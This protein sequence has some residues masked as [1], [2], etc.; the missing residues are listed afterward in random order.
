[1]RNLVVKRI[2]KRTSK[3]TKE[4]VRKLAKRVAADYTEPDLIALCKAGDI[5]D[6]YVGS[7]AMRELLY[8]LYAGIY[9]RFITKEQKDFIQAFR[10]K[11]Q[12]AVDNSPE[13]FNRDTYRI[14]REAEQREKQENSLYIY[15]QLGEHQICQRCNYT[16]CPT[17]GM[18]PTCDPN[19]FERHY[20][21]NILTKHE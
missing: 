5:H 2:L 19:L 11:M 12:L 10:F 20:I 17:Q 13:G 4:L 18:C 15:H 16:Y 14:L 1:M 6:W 3:E 8:E 9:P 21:T 7:E